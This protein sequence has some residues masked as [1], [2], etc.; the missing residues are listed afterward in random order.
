MVGMLNV[1]GNETLSSVVLVSRYIY[2]IYAHFKSF[3]ARF[4]VV[5]LRYKAKMK[6][7]FSGDKKLT[8]G[9]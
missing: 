9:T 5:L 7:L 6:F 2:E 3:F 4:Q 1:E 8:L